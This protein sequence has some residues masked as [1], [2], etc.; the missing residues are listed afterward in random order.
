MADEKDTIEHIKQ[1][2]ALTED[3]LEYQAVDVAAAYDRVE[4]RIHRKAAKRVWMQTVFRVAAVLLL[5]LLMSSLLFSYLYFDQRKYMAEGMYQEVVSAPGTVTRIQLPDR[6]TVWLNAGSTLRYPSAFTGREREVELSGEGYFSVQSDREH[7]FYVATADGLKVM[8]YGTQF[9]V[10]AYADEPLIE[11]VL[12]RGKIDVIRNGQTVR[13]EPGKQA[14]LCKATGQFTVSTVNLDEKTGWKDGRL[15]FRN[16][17]LEEVLKKL[18]KRYNTDIVLHKKSEKEYRYRATFTTETVEQIL[19][20]LRL[21]APIEW[22]VKEPEQVSDDSF[23]RGRIDV[24][25]K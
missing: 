22:S 7:P 4:K 2:Q 20:Y 9:N 14:V 21:T 15:V 23:V 18:S 6:S 5:P 13:L 24:Y 3:I 19:N 17:P 11:A 10:N 25:Q 8:A 12:E 16:A 1:I